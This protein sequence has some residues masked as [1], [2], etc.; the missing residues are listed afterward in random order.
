MGDALCKRGKLTLSAGR[1]AVKHTDPVARRDGRK[2][3]AS[4]PKG[5]PYT[6]PNGNPP[7]LTAKKALDSCKDNPSESK[8]A[9][10]WKP[11]P[12]RET[13]RAQATCAG[14]VRRRRN[15]VPAGIGAGHLPKL[16]ASACSTRDDVSCPRSRCQ[17]FPPVAKRFCCTRDKLA[18]L[19][20]NCQLVPHGARPDCSGRE[21]LADASAPQQRPA[22]TPP[23]RAR[24]TP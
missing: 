14:N 2:S 4:P 12:P 1:L 20:E 19:P 5:G 21:K 7:C 13:G 3:G 9:P 24:R 10:Q 17:L 6:E 16:S 11:A 15:R 22:A 23:H 8:S 18:H